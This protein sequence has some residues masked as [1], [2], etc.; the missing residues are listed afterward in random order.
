M[1]SADLRAGVVATG[2]AMAAGGLVEGSQGNV[3]ARLGK[4]VLITPRD[5][6]YAGMRPGD[7]VEIDL[8]GAVLDG[9]RE[10]SSEWRVHA[11]VY[12]ARPDV[13]AVVHTHSPRAV[14]WSHHGVELPVPGGL[15][16]V[17]CAPAAPAGSPELARAVAATLAD[18]EAVLMTGH[19]VVAVGAGLE[20]ALAV[21][22]EVERRAAAATDEA[23]SV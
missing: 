15:A 18:G 14:R 10:P 12:A 3:S 1:P 2:Q 21:A 11:A 16:S 6:P 19:G 23:P 20:E 8:E 4:R 22:R 17:R 13:G 5:T 7:L 9:V